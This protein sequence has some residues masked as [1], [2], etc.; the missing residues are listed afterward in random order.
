MSV[1]DDEESTPPRVPAANQGGQY[2]PGF[3]LD[4]L[5][6]LLKADPLG[7]VHPICAYKRKDMLLDK[8]KHQTCIDQ[9]GICIEYFFSA[10]TISLLGSALASLYPECG[11]L[12]IYRIRDWVCG[13]SPC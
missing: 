8:Q 11:W 1:R 10:R 4:R 6:H 7:L 12:G 2:G 9:G 3:Q 13:N 5:C